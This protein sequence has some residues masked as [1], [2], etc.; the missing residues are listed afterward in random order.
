M[1]AGIHANSPVK[2]SVVRRVFWSY[3]IVVV[4]F[5]LVAGWGARALRSAAPEA[6]LMRAGYYP[7]ALA[8]RDLAAKQDT[9]NSQLNHIT[10]AR[11]P[12][13]LRV[14]F[15]FALKIGRPK[16]F[17]EARAAIGRAFLGSGVAVRLVLLDD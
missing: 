16:L 1:N 6:S 2:R 9:Y 4:A 17:G 12:A 10:A 3:V 8:V 13:D 5:A 14:W 7:M 11:N 15:D